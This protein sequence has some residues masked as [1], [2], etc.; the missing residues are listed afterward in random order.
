MHLSLASKR[1]SQNL[2]R[3]RAYQ[4]FSL[5]SV[6]ASSLTNDKSELRDCGYRFLDP[7]IT[8]KVDLIDQFP[9][10]LSESDIDAEALAA[11]CFPN[12]LRIR[13]IPRCAE[14]GAKRLGWI[15]ENGDSYQLQGFTDVAGSLSHGCAITIKEE[16]THSDASN[17]FSV[18]FLH[19]ERRRSAAIIARWVCKQF[20]R[21]E[22]SPSGPA[23][24][25]KPMVKRA[26]SMVEKASSMKW[27]RKGSDEDGHRK[28]EDRNSAAGLRAAMDKVMSINRSRK[29][30]FK[31]ASMGDLAFDESD[32]SDDDSL[33][34][35]YED[36]CYPLPPSEHIRRLGISAYQ[37]MV[38]A[39]KDGDI[40]IVEK[41][42]VLTGTRLQDQSLFFC[43][44]QNLIDMERKIN[45]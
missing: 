41:S 23:F 42:Y 1:F 16:I 36:E 20:K 29:G 19:R 44:L 34:R 8:K 25:S 9:S 18:I 13:L 33:G 38:N 28:T 6:C 15:G 21:P 3:D 45:D 10:G 30:K 4:Q 12:G 11:F 14:E 22:R 40:C 26:N 27:G 37:A 5:L 17:V 24:G 39:E 7:F 43:A 32:P 31:S 35:E 2:E